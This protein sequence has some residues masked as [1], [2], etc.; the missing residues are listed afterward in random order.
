M[1]RGCCSPDRANDVALLQLA[2][3]A[4]LGATVGVPCL[5]SQGDYGDTSHYPPGMEVR[6]NNRQSSLSGLI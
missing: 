1:T 2:A 5:P 6:G 4:S 3:P